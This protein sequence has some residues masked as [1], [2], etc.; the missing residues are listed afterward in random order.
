ML[1]TA[2]KK[3]G[4]LKANNSGRISRSSMHSSDEDDKSKIV[5]LEQQVWTLH[6]YYILE[7]LKCVLADR[8]SGGPTGG[9]TFRG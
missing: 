6:S 4:D 5:Y 1:E 3:I 7:N 9:G 8:W 2:Q